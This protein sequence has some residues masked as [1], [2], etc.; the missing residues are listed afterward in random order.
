MRWHRCAAS[1][2]WL[3]DLPCVAR[4]CVQNRLHLI[5]RE[6]TTS[7]MM[8]RT[9][10]WLNRN[11]TLAVQVLISLDTQAELPGDRDRGTFEI[12]AWYQPRLC[13][14]AKRVMFSPSRSA[15]DHRVIHVHE[16]L[17]AL[18]HGVF[19]LSEGRRSREQRRALVC[20]GAGLTF[21][22]REEDWS[23]R[24]VHMMAPSR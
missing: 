15:D 6:D 18:I 9:P 10:P 16:P 5:F 7:R 1:S 2:S 17:A 24:I 4:N 22:I 3:G 12:E 11:V 19:V 14:S 23:R 8:F 20:R 21:R 13:S